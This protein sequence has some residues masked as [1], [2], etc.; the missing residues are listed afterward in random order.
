MHYLIG[1]MRGEERCSDYRGAI[2]YGLGLTVLSEMEAGNWVPIMRTDDDL[3]RLREQEQLLPNQLRGGAAMIAKMLAGLLAFSLAVSAP[4][5]LA[6]EQFNPVA[7]YTADDELSAELED[8]LA[9]LDGEYGIAVESLSGG[10]SIYINADGEFLTA[11]MYKVLVMYRVMEAVEAGELSLGDTITITEADTIE[12]TDG[13][14]M[15]EGTSLSIGDALHAMIAYSDNAAAYALTREV[16]GWGSVEAAASELGM[17]NTYFNGQFWS[18]PADMELFFAQLANGSL[19]SAD[20]SDYMIDLLM[21]QTKNDRIP[22][23]LPPEATVAHKTGE[24]PSV[25]NDGGIVYGPNGD[26]I[27]V[28]M[29]QAD[30]GEAV[31][32]E[33]EISR[34]VYDAFGT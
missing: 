10:D 4:A 28:V 1:I 33:A 17:S 2:G 20:A 24:L 30:P 5:A 11:S 8:Y 34:M 21:A 19:V 25:R 16:G 26:Y 15:A 14:G 29:S 23:L 9:G 22:A 27:I 3:R 32:A 6:S 7:R 12:N 18:S 13:D 31:A